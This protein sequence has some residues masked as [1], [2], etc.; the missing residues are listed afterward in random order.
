MGWFGLADWLSICYSQSTPR[1]K[2]I[3]FVAIDFSL[4]ILQYSVG[5]PEPQTVGWPLCNSC[6]G[7]VG[8]LSL[9]RHALATT[10]YCWNWWTSFMTRFAGGLNSRYWSGVVGSCCKFHLIVRLQNSWGDC[11]CSKCPELFGL[12]SSFAF[13]SVD[14]SV[15]LYAPAVASWRRLVFAALPTGPELGRVRLNAHSVIAASYFQLLRFDSPRFV[16]I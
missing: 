10:L 11:F 9:C 16:A 2:K 3:H 1:K 5:H 13:D 15:W 14:E 7:Q 12:A 4:A 6:N 8:I